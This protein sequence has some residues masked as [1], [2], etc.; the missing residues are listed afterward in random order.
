MKEKTREIYI[1]SSPNAFHVKN[2][3]RYLPYA[4]LG[5]KNPESAVSYC[6]QNAVCLSLHLG[7]ENNY[8]AMNGVQ[9]HAVALVLISHQDTVHYKMTANNLFPPRAAMFL[10][11]RKYRHKRH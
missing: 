6:C 10:H 9:V 11:Y 2:V 7:N 4:Y 5:Y 1:N 3:R 8:F